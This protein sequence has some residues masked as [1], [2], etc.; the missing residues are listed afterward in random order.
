MFSV[1]F[2]TN[3]E[4][5]TFAFF[6]FLSQAL[7]QDVRDACESTQTEIQFGI[8]VTTTAASI[9]QIMY[10]TNKKTLVTLKLV[11]E[12]FREAELNNDGCRNAEKKAVREYPWMLS[13]F[14]AQIIQLRGVG[15]CVN[16][17]PAK[18]DFTLQ[19]SFWFFL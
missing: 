7:L 17:A 6:V 18:D 10:K 3:T 9:S 8:R 4:F 11:Q 12:Q 19:Q 15:M 5:L 1:H 2:S 13:G 16:V 14:P